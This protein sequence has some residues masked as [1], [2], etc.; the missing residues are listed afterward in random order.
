M[1]IFL[2]AV[3]LATA[4]AA[5]VGVIAQYHVNYA[6]WISLGIP[7]I[8]GKSLDFMLFFTTESNLLGVVVLTVGGLRL[9]RGKVDASVA[10]AT[11]RLSST[12]YLIITGIVWNLLLRGQP[13]PPA[14]Q[15][16]WANQIVHVAVPIVVLL[17]WLI[18]PDRT[19][20][21]GGAI[22]RLIIFPLVW[23]GVTLG[24]GPFTGDQVTGSS[25]YYPYGFLDPSS[26]PSGYL[27][28]GEYV[29]GLTV[30][31]CVISG[32]LIAVTRVRPPVGGATSSLRTRGA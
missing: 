32:L 18:A 7:G 14:L 11:L 28:V 19:R 8:A 13:G 20:L 27:S 29:V 3:R 31:L 30:A 15:L 16:D 9:A 5:L 12:V 24:R 21:G 1:R 25:T 10:W 2:S 4:A 23:I 17:D 22:G 26:S 6:Y